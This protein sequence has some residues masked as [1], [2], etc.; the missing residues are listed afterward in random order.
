MLLGYKYNSLPSNF[1]DINTN[2][3]REHDKGVDSNFPMRNSSY[4]GHHKHDMYEEERQRKFL[5]EVEDLNSRRH[6][7]FFT[8]S[9]KS[10][11]PLNRYDNF[12]ADLAP[13]SPRSFYVSG[14]ARALY[15][16][17]GE[18]SRY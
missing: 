11:I 15:D 8:S 18:N 5:Q 4:Q 13:K 2:F 10:P 9:Q 6:T 17:N 3:S 7:D 16:F 1:P 14:A 12:V